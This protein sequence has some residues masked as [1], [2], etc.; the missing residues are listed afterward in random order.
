[1]EESRNIS[2]GSEAERW[3]KLCKILHK[4]GKSIQARSDA[5]GLRGPTFS[6]PASERWALRGP[7][8]G[9]LGASFVEGN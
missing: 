6:P 4:I 2:L 9:S 3:R 5:A 7:L 8:A 1:M